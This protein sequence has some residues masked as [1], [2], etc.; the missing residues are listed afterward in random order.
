MGSHSVTCLPAQ[1]NTPHLNPSQTGHFPGNNNNN[2]NEIVECYSAEASEAQTWVRR[3][4]PWFSV[5]THPYPDH[6]HG[7]ADTVHIH[8]ILCT[9]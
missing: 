6:P 3:L 2:K 9:V 8:R 1:V 4:V 5:S 7:Q